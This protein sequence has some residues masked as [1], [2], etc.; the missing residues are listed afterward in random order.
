M[1]NNN[2]KVSIVTP[3]YQAEQ[4]VQRYIDMVL[5]F[6]YDNIELILI[7][8]GSTDRTNEIVELN[9][10]TIQNANIILKYINL[11]NNMGQAY[12]INEALKIVTGKYMC[13]CDVD[14]IYLPNCISKLV[15]AMVNNPDCK[16][17]FANCEIVKSDDLNCPVAKP[18][19]KVVHKDI[20][21]DCIFDKNIMSSPIRGF[22]ETEALFKVLKNKSIYTSRAGQN[23]QLILPMVERYKWTYVEDILSKYVLYQSSHSHSC[24]IG[25]RNKELIDLFTNI[26]DDMNISLSKKLYYKFL[27]YFNFTKK[28]LNNL[29]KININFKR[30][31]VRIIVFKKEIINTEWKF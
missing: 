30:K 26:F 28:D 24:D 3:M 7:N 5:A 10:K 11:E 27:V 14:D 9:R 15:Q 25:K 19:H 31:F 8:D 23:F 17:A 16:I 1:N 2:P 18:K 6:D 22:V 13:W 20:L 21:A 4:F 12:A 29:L